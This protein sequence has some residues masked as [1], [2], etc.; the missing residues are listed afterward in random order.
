ME[1]QEGLTILVTGF[2]PFKDNKINASWEA[3]K[4]LPD[5]F[6]S[7][8]ETSQINLI[9][10]EIPVAYKIVSS[11]IQELWE[12]HKPSIIMHVGLSTKANCLVIE[13][14]ANSKG[15]DQPDILNEHPDENEVDQE[16]L[17]STCDVQKI[18]QIVNEESNVS[19]CKACTSCDAGRYLCEYIYYQSLSLR[20]PL[21]LFVHVP[22]KDVYGFEKTAHGLLRILIHLI[23][24]AVEKKSADE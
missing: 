4:L 23:E 11:K 6:K 20:N 21:V 16:I 24:C 10:E 13:C 15:Y 7:N 2:G 14:E 19:D 8:P 18:C 3:V 1:K 9:I 17:Q 12:Q 5:L 22:P